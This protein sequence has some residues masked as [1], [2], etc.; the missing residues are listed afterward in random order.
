MLALY[1]SG[2][3]AEAL[4]AYREARRVA[5]TSS[6][7]SRGPELQALERAVL[8]QDPAL[9]APAPSQARRRDLP[10]PL[11]PLVGRELEVAAVAALLGGPRCGC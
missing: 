6:G 7:S 1:R 2:R 11:T 9:A 4:E 10:R 8:Q 3:Q 5:A